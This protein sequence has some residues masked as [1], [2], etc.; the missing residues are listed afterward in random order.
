MMKSLKEDLSGSTLWLLLLILG[1]YI[2]LIIISRT[3]NPANA[4]MPTFVY[5]F[6]VMFF[7]FI[8]YFKV[9]KKATSSFILRA[10]I[11]NSPNTEDL[12]VYLLVE[13]AID[14]DIRR[15]IDI[16]KYED[17]V[18][19]Q[20]R[21]LEEIKDAITKKKEFMRDKSILL[22]KGKTTPQ[23]IE[24]EIKK[25]FP[26]NNNI[27]YDK[28]IDTKN[29][30]YVSW[31]KLLEA[32]FLEA[33]PNDEFNKC[34]IVSHRPF[35]K[36]FPFQTREEILDNYW[37]RCKST[38]AELIRW[39][40]INFDFPVFYSNFTAADNQQ[41][42]EKSLDASTIV[43]IENRTMKHI[44]ASQRQEYQDVN[45]MKVQYQQNLLKKDEIIHSLRGQL[46]M[47]M[48]E[49]IVN[50]IKKTEPPKGLPKWQVFLLSVMFILLIIAV[51]VK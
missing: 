1:G 22:D 19:Y 25:Q 23:Q 46:H 31:V 26:D 21:I 24:N 8:Q 45:A 14:L 42:I 5:L 43:H 12:D 2:P 15:N 35:S 17:Y 41:P 18:F 48:A 40:S 30:I 16:S 33:T 20:D 7:A 10:N 11:T 50:K 13:F 49:P 44:I 9:Y 39:P 32:Q 6:V 37:I 47:S 3:D 4:I 38:R 36:E 28:S 29:R 51:V 27:N 34:I